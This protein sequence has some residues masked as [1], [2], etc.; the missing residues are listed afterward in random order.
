MGVGG[1]VVE[2]SKPS[3]GYVPASS[4]LKSPMFVFLLSDSTRDVKLNFQTTLKC[5]VQCHL[6]Y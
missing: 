4:P 6:V 2:A 3:E 5:I 1:R